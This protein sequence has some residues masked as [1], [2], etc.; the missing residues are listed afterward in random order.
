[1]PQFD[2][3]NSGLLFKKDRKT[4]KHPALTGFLDVEGVQYNV[5]VWPMKHQDGSAKVSKKGEQ[6]Y[7]I[8]VEAQDGQERVPI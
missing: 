3:T 5:S 8:K 4:T 6:M 7:S 1:M 2:N